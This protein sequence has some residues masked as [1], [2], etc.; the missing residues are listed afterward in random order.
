MKMKYIYVSL[1]SNVFDEYFSTQYNI[2]Q[3]FDLN[4]KIN[5][6]E[7]EEKSSII[8]SS[9]HPMD[10]LTLSERK[11]NITTRTC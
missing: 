7:I 6:F 4:S 10:S 9:A 8:T 1:E 5:L 11:F 3:Y 2:W